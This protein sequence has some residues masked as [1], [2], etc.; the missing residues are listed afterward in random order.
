MWLQYFFRYKDYKGLSGDE[1]VQL[2]RLLQREDSALWLQTLSPAELE[3]FDSLVEAFK[4]S[5]FH[6]PN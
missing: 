4:S 2:F 3:D 5:F 6:R 1:A